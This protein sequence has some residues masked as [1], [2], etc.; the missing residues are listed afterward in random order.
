M[1]RPFLFPLLLLTCN[2]VLAQAPV[3]QSPPLGWNSY[4]AYGA[5]VTEAEV[6]ENAAY[7][8]EYLRPRGWQ[9]VVVDFCWSYAHPPTSTQSNPK[10]FR[11]EDGAHVPWLNMDAYGRLLPDERKF[12]SSARGAGFKPLADYVHGLGLKFGIHVMRGIPK[13]AVWAKSPIL[14]TNGITADQIADTTSTCPWL[15]HMYGVD[16]KKPGAQAYYNSLLDLYAQ[17]GV[18]YIKVDDLGVEK[19]APNGNTFT[20]YKNEVEAIRSAITNTRRPFVF[21]VSP[22]QP[23]SNSEH[24]R[25]HANL[26]RISNDFWDEWPQLKKQ[27]DYCAEWATVGAPGHWPD[28]DMLQLGKIA[29]R[30]PVAKPRFS[31]FT[32]AEQRTHMTLWCMARSPLMM[33]GNLPDNSVFV[34]NLLTNEEALAA[35]Q[36]A[37]NS[38]QASRNGDL[39]MWTSEAADGRSHH[40]ALFNL[41]DQPAPMTVDFAQLGAGKKANVRDIW[42]KAYRGL[43]KKDYTVQI[44]PHDVVFLRVTGI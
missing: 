18:D 22:F 27:F 29:K 4:N 43:F 31:R 40:V 41:G 38:R 35:N 42:Q 24:L 1:K 7:M 16:M 12:P 8:A 13:Q 32:E 39:V 17:W 20:Y 6:K 21:S 28:A 15:N 5:T 25:Q 10:Q 19:A 33:G 23:F 36:T 44:P 14:G 9:F 3:A 37:T 2:M 30:G 11:L 26:F 34:N